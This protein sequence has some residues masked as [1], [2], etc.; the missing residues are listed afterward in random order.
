M[1]INPCLP[2][3]QITIRISENALF[4][5]A[6]IQEKK[7]KQQ[8]GLQKKTVVSRDLVWLGTVCEL[9]TMNNALDTCMYM[10]SFIH[11]YML[12]NSKLL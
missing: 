3:P 7:K 6:R 5:R 9:V 4:L 11:M 8:L 10:H 12:Y 2:P 1:R